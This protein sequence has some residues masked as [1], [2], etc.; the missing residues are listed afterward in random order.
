MSCY[1]FALTTEQPQISIDTTVATVEITQT[2]VIV[3]A[4]TTNQGVFLTISYEGF[5][6]C[7]TI[8]IG[9]FSCLV[10]R[11]ISYIRIV[12]TT[13]VEFGLPSRI[14]SL[15]DDVQLMDGYEVFTT[16]NVVETFHVMYDCIIVSTCC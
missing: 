4:I 16:L 6:Q 1:L 10:G 15:P 2:V 3:I 11:V 7:P 14:E 12:D 9:C 13:T 5:T 8:T